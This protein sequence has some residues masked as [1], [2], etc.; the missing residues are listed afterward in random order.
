MPAQSSFPRKRES[1]AKHS[2][3]TTFPWIPVGAGMTKER[4]LENWIATKTPP[5]DWPE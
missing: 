2:V 3:F 5:K 1:R 4:A